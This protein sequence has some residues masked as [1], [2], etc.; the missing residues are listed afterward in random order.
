MVSHHSGYSESL[1][2][3]LCVEIR[4]PTNMIFAKYEGHISTVDSSSSPLYPVQRP[5]LLSRNE[6]IVYLDVSNY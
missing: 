2:T 3:G 1:Q 6:Q 5:L 4:T